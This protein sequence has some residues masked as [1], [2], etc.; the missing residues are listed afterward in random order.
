MSAV[1]IPWLTGCPA[2]RTTHVP[3][4][5]LWTATVPFICEH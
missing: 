3:A 2:V 1:H 5:T 4:R